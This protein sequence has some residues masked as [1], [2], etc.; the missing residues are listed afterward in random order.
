MSGIGLSLHEY[1]DAHF[2]SKNKVKKGEWNNLELV[3]DVDTLEMFLNGESSG[4]VKILQPGR[5]NSN[6]WFGGRPKA[7]F[8]GSVR[9]VRVRHGW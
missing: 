1:G 4:K 9:D 5:S 3:S 2:R 8:R 6:C 7:L